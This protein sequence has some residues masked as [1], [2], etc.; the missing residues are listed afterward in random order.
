MG[1]RY[2]PTLGF[3]F[4]AKCSSMFYTWIL[5]GMFLVFF[6]N[7]KVPKSVTAVVSTAGFNSNSST[8]VLLKMPR[9]T[10]MKSILVRGVSFVSKKIQY[11]IGYIYPMSL[12]DHE[13]HRS[14]EMTSI[15]YVKFKKQG[16]F[17]F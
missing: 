16:F 3:K 7:L 12:S 15:I 8:P 14:K 6:L 5:W 4:I 11:A 1:L 9:L 17:D 13:K 2:L 10:W